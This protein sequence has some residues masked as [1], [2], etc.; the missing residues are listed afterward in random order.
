[1]NNR[2]RAEYL[3]GESAIALKGHVQ[4]DNGALFFHSEDTG[5]ETG[6]SEFCFD[7]I[8]DVRQSNE[9]TIL[10]IGK[11]NSPVFHKTIILFDEDGAFSASW[12]MWSTRKNKLGWLVQT[13]GNWPF[14]YKV[15]FGGILSTL[16]IGCCLLFFFQIHSIVPL[17]V[18]RYLGKRVFEQLED[19]FSVCQKPVLQKTVK[20]LLEKIVPVN[21]PF[22]YQFLIV[23]DSRINAFALPGGHLVIL[24]GLLENTESVEELAGVLAHEISH[25]EER[26][27]IRSL[28]RYAG[29]HYLISMM[30]GVGFEE[31]EAIETF[32]ELSSLLV[33][34]KYSKSFEL[35]A[36]RNAIKYLEKAQISTEG[37]K[38]FL[39]RLEQRSSRNPGMKTLEAALG[40]FSTHP[41]TDYRVRVLEKYSTPKGEMTENAKG[42]S[43]IKALCQ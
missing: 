22:Q 43:K 38:S 7:E 36:D 27:G 5:M 18:D 10:L 15:F 31:V 41:E 2:I 16:V 6:K 17:A 33:Y 25:V 20:R 12:G 3:N 14:G 19:R 34:F 26:H 1:M 28:I 42:W 24:S 4:V 9:Q 23:Q 11:K 40:W 35:E 29:V 39:A 37:L 32:G 30:F 13:V 21:S 8:I